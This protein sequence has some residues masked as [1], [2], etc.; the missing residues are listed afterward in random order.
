[1]KRIKDDAIALTEEE[2]EKEPGQEV[3]TL[4]FSEVLQEEENLKKT[5]YYNDRTL[6]DESKYYKLYQ[7][8]AD[9][10]KPFDNPLDHP[11]YLSKKAVTSQLEA[12]VDNYDDFY[13]SVR[14]TKTHINT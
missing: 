3:T 9:F 14:T 7:Q 12:I 11:G 4:N 13:S 1:M 5:T 10:M 6:A 8:L 2:L